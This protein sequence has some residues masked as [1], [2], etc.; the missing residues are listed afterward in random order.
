MQTFVQQKEMLL[1]ITPV[2]KHGEFPG[3]QPQ[4]QQLPRNIQWEEV[5][6]F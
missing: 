2:Q 1:S 3:T 5:I 4:K 6:L